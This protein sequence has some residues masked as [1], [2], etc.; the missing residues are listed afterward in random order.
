MFTNCRP[1]IK[2]KAKNDM[3]CDRG[4]GEVGNDSRGIVDPSCSGVRGV[5]QAGNGTGETKIS[6]VRVRL[7]RKN[8]TVEIFAWES[9]RQRYLWQLELSLFVT[10]VCP[11]HLFPSILPLFF[12]PSQ[13]V[14]IALHCVSNDDSY[15]GHF[16]VWRRTQCVVKK[17][18]N[19]N[20]KTPNHGTVYNTMNA[21]AVNT[22]K[23]HRQRRGGGGEIE[24][25]AIFL[26]NGS[27]NG[28]VFWG[29]TWK[30]RR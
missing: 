4:G 29:Q 19:N 6:R 3:C 11:R 20:K 13:P 24:E 10:P 9:T 23:V 7:I 22:K 25:W 21:T 18:T 17:K 12:S 26:L 15:S 30:F 2:V 27:K 16:S 14:L 28:L 1:G 5:S 8:R